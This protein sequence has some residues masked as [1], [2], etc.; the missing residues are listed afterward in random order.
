LSLKLKILAVRVGTNFSIG[1]IYCSIEFENQQ[2]NIQM[3][4]ESRLVASSIVWRAKQEL[5]VGAS[6]NSSMLPSNAY[7]ENTPKRLNLRESLQLPEVISWE[8]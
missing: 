4:D 3:N 6:I 8:I 5:A 7:S 1:K 2:T